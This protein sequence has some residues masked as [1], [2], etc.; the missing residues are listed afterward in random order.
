MGRGGRR[1]ARLLL[2]IGSS[3]TR[4]ATHPEVRRSVCPVATGEKCGVLHT[5]VVIADDDALLITNANLIE[6]TLERNVEAGLL[7]VRDAVLAHSAVRQRAK[8]IK[9]GTCCGYPT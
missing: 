4:L 7:V 8:L 6:A 9:T 1:R 2:L 5:R 3:V